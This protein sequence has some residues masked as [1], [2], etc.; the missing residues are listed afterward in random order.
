MSNINFFRVLQNYIATGIP[1][2]FNDRLGPLNN[3]VTKIVLDSDG[4][5]RIV[6]SFS[7]I[8]GT[9]VGRL[10]KISPN[11]TFDTSFNSGTG[12]GFAGSGVT[13]N[14][15]GI[16][17][18]GSMVVSTNSTSY[19]TDT[20]IYLAKIASDGA[21]NSTFVTNQGTGFFQ[22]TNQIIVDSNDKIIVTF[23]G[24]DWNGNT[25]KK[26]IRFNSNGTEDTSFYTNLGTAFV[27]QPSAIPYIQS[28]GKILLG[29][30]FTSFNS[31]TSRKYLIRLNSSGTIDS[32][33][34]TNLGNGFNSGTNV[35]EV[36]SDG[37]ILVGGYFT[38]LDG[39]TRNRL[40]RLNSNGTEDTSF[41]TNLGTGFNGYINDVKVLS[42]GKII[43]VGNFS[44]V[45]GTSIDCVAALNSNGSVDTTWI[46][47]FGSGVGSGQILTIAVQSDDSVIIG[48]NFYNMNGITPG[49][50]F[51][52]KANSDGTRA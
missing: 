50:N 17:S 7:T 3:Q 16:L 36:Q 1:E 13:T 2:Y 51:I 48:G 25:R 23:T 35:I 46:S 38:S 27:Q 43:V 8:D 28:D 37:K 33:F 31:N 24:N 22:T 40:V 44:S 26:I 10:A 9:S 4:K 32:S 47:N 14:S 52:Y 19:D 18:D 11:G 34:S 21:L 49:I 42:S 12:I 45:D 39:N 6:G 5:N 30:P 29:G 15:V 20:I 41:Y